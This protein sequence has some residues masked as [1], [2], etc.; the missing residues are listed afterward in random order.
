[1]RGRHPLKEVVVTVTVSP[2][3]CPD[4]ETV[5]KG[6]QLGLTDDQPV[7]VP[8]KLL[9]GL[10]TKFSMVWVRQEARVESRKTPDSRP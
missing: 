2:E 7:V 4:T 9:S 1:V 6:G 5:T 8:V 3:N 10:K